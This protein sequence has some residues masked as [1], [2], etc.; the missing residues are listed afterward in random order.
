MS[1]LSGESGAAG[2]GAFPGPK[3]KDPFPFLRRF[4]GFNTFFSFSTLRKVSVNQQSCSSV[5]IQKDAQT[6]DKYL[7]T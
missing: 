5:A 1:A 4:M 3:R 7:S 6:P 2:S